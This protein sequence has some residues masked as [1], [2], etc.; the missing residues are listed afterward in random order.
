MLQSVRRE[1]RKSQHRAML[2]FL[3]ALL[4]L[5]SLVTA[6][7]S[8]GGLTLVRFDNTALAGDGVKSE[9]ASS[10]EAV[11]TC[12]TAVG[13]SCAA[14]SSMLLVGRLAPESAG[15][16]GFH[17]AFDPPLQYPSDEAYSRLWVDDHLL[18]P[19]RTG[20]PSASS[21]GNVAA[22]WIPLPPRALDAHGGIVESAGSAPLGSYEVR[23]EYVCMALGGCPARTATLRWASLPGPYASAPFLPIPP[24]VLL[25]T[26]GAPEIAR[27]SLATRQEAGWGTFDHQSEL[28]WVLLPESFV[29]QLGLYRLS[30]GAFLPPT[31]LTVHKPTPAGGHATV[32]PNP[33]FVMK[34]GL[35][36]LDQAY[37]EASVLWSGD[38]SCNISCANALNV[39]IA[40]T[41]QGAELTMAV[42]V[43]N[44]GENGLLNASDYALILIP[45]FTNG[46]AGSVSA[47]SHGVSGLSA[48]LRSTTF[49]LVAGRSAS[50]SSPVLPSVH[51]AVPLSGTAPVVL[52]TDSSASAAAVLARTSDYR[53][54][55]LATLDK[56]GAWANVKDAVQ[57]SLM[58]S[59]VY[60]PKQSLVAPSYGYNVGDGGPSGPTATVD[61]DTAV[62]TF[63]WDQSFV[64]YMFGLDAP[65]L[66]LSNLIAV[67][68]L[69]TAAGY[70][71][72]FASGNAK[73]RG[74]TQ[75]PVTS[76]ALFEVAK[77]WGVNRTRF[78]L[79]LC[80][81]DLFV[82]NT[83][84]YTQRRLLPLGLITYGSSPYDS[85][86][87]DGSSQS[88]VPG[89]SNGESGLDNGPTTEGMGC[90]NQSGQFLQNQY[91]A[92][93]TGLYLMDT[94]ALLGLAKMTGRDTAATELQRRLES[95][96]KVMVSALWNASEGLFQ[97]KRPAPLS[98][99][100][101]LAPTHFYPLLAGPEHGP[102]EAIAVTTVK[103][104]LTNPE[105]MAVWPTQE[106]PADVPPEYARPLVQWYSQ[107]IDSRGNGNTSG[108]HVLCCQPECNYKYA[109][110]DF[111]QRTHG[112]VRYEGMAIASHAAA[113]AD[114]TASLG[115]PTGVTPMPLFEYQCASTASADFTVA[116]AGW[117]PTHGGPCRQLSSAVALFVLPAR[118]GPAAASLVELQ[119]WYKEGDHYVVASPAGEADA[120][121]KGYRRVDSLGYVWP[122]PGT[123]NATSRYGLP[124]ISKDDHNYAFQDYWRGRIWT[125]MLQLVAWGLEEYSSA[126]VREALAG[127]AQ[128][129]KAVL[130]RPWMGFES[131]DGYSGTGRR[132]YENYDADTAEGYSYSSSAFPMYAWGAL[133]GFVG[134]RTEGFYAP[135]N[136]SAIGAYV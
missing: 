118:L 64:G 122:A 124:S 126:E 59:L 81:D 85:W 101:M 115:L 18:Y 116:G 109:V 90:V 87:P 12:G 52:S 39:S 37:I 5:A 84:L 99:I 13:V 72:G 103:R 35:H 67:V 11:T 106:M 119:M 68:K 132:V 104:G 41:V 83:W 9:L 112:K 91:S 78:A 26:Q 43:L 23:L 117:K 88:S 93:Q 135:L 98:S 123:A 130:L 129:S 28:T 31:G 127:L 77:R 95:V 20:P 38:T 97:N 100:E 29:V 111:V 16:F 33:E 44:S 56:Y 10:L 2:A 50:L 51:L 82:Q 21:K 15:R 1:G 27:R 34:A 107:K 55:E 30:T 96:S 24:S 74:G 108:P 92:G 49:S 79:D 53:A 42:T 65:G 94:K 17:L 105:K 75:P 102:S 6:D 134:L 110:G 128:Q 60:D 61:G 69:K 62:N 8:A 125:P 73:T 71:P 25:P 48:G 86:A 58:W 7:T 3:P 66:A 63:V 54:K 45:N 133:A 136:A 40:T 113:A 47:N 121:S 4:P 131:S 14:P 70:I 80:F 19:N 46:R 89:C 114:L 120:L 32:H 22:R 36:S 57:T 76:K